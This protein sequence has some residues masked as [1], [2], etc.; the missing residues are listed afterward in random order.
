[1]TG[2]LVAGCSEEEPQEFSGD[3]RSGFLAA[4][5]YPLEDTLLTSSICQ[6][7]YDESLVQVPFTRFAAI[8]REL[9][10]EEGDHELPEELVE[11]VVQ[12]VIEEAEL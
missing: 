7:V 1:M 12:C 10:D 3:N 6:C 4:C 11:I 9:R 2:S 8:E 5:I